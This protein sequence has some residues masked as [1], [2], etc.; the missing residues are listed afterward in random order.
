[1]HPKE[2]CIH[3][4]GA[5]AST[6]KSKKKYIIHFGDVILFPE[7]QLLKTNIHSLITFL[8][9]HRHYIDDLSLHDPLHV[10][11]NMSNTLPEQIDELKGILVD[12]IAHVLK[13]EAHYPVIQENR[14][15]NI[16]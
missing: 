7:D 6:Q 11:Y 12:L 15:E 1:M 16:L 13:L 5:A 3:A 10:V 14:N 2:S 8:Y 4:L 9:F